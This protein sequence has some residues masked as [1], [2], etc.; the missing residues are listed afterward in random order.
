MIV[1]HNQKR[2]IKASM[3]W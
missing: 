1:V 2:V 3:T